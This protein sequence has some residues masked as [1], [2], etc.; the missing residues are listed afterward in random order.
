MAFFSSVGKYR[1][2]RDVRLVTQLVLKC[3]VLKSQRPLDIRY[4]KISYIGS[5]GCFLV[6]TFILNGR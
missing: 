5:S 4:I 1:S 3:G 2:K 6:I